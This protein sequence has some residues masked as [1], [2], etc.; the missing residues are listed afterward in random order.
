MV[1][2][3]S[4]DEARKF[5]GPSLAGADGELEAS[6]RALEFAHLRVKIVGGLPPS[7]E[8]LL[9]E[10]SGARRKSDA[11]LQARMTPPEVQAQREAKAEVREE[12][13][14]TITLPLPLTL[15]LTLTLTRHGPTRPARAL[16]PLD[17]DRAR[18]LPSAPCG[19]S[20]AAA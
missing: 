6:K 2:A 1:L 15:T 5:E 16:L 10:L 8:G 3:V 13:T 9:A 17:P 14:L 7:A 4:S 12:L 19:R 20:A 11:T 18:R